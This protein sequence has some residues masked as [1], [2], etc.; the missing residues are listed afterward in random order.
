VLP[1]RARRLFRLAVRRSALLE[2]EVDDEIAFHLEARAAQLVARHMSAEDARAEALRRFGDVG[3]ARQ[4]LNRSATRHEAR[5]QLREL[6]ASTWQ[7]VHY[8]ARGIR[9]SPGFATAVI[10]TLALGIGANA[11]MFGVVDRLLL[12]PPAGVRAPDEVNRIYLTTANGFQGMQLGTNQSYRRY[13]DLVQNVHTVSDIAAHYETERVFGLGE[14]ARQE[15]TSMVTASFWPLIGVRP[16]LGRFFDDAEDRLPRGT[17]VAVLG[18]GYWQSQFGGRRDVL[19]RTLRIGGTDY[20]IVGVV[21]A[22]FSGLSL[23]PVA[24]FVPL[25]A[26]GADMFHDFGGVKWSEQYRV[27]WLQT[28]IR[29]KPGVSVQAATADLTNAFRQSIETQRP[30]E[31]AGLLAMDRMNPQATL[32]SVLESRGPKR[33][34][35]ATVSLWLMAVSGLVLVMACANVANLLIARALRRRREI[36]IRQALGVSR[37]RLLAQLLTE[38][39]LLAL[40]GGVAGVLVAQWGGALLRSVLLPTLDWSGGAFDHRVLLFAGVIALG[41]GL[42]T[43]LAPIRQLSRSDVATAL[44]SGGRGASLRSSRLRKGLLVVQGAVSVILLVGAGLFV[45]SFRNVRSLDLGFQPE[46]VLTA[47]V[48][49]RGVT[50]DSMQRQ[51]LAQQMRD[52]ALTLPGVEHATTGLTVPFSS[53]WTQ[54]IVVPGID[55][56]RLRDF[57]YVV[58]AGPDY[59]ATMGTRLVS[60]RAITDADRAGTE[61]VV[62]VSQGAARRIWPGTNPIGR[63]IKLG[64]DAPCMT[65]IGTAQDTRASFDD[66]PRPQL[67]VPI[68]QES[69]PEVRLFVR[70]RGDAARSTESVRRALQELMPGAAYVNAAA[71]EEVVASESRSWRLGATMFTIFGLLALL[72]AA[73]GLYSVV[74]Y[75][76]SQRTQ[77][78]GVRVALGASTA[79]VI[80]LVL[81]EGVRVVA[82]GLGLGAIV[83]LALANRITPMLY[84][85]TGKDPITYGLVGVVLLAVAIVASLAPALRAAHVDPNVALR[86]E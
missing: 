27:G 74:A 75:D 38:S 69:Q 41:A 81:A 21:P 1:P 47:G 16:V 50:L 59:L 61:R 62:V 7:D 36:A 52:R 14:G 57:F 60:G 6:F 18:Y 76:V 86:A 45:R 49:F 55:T 32:G 29:R 9:R 85:V 63:C 84:H 10:L 22:G 72:V 26:G 37:G 25:T 24:A 19:G 33:S 31:P 54:P 39:T 40:L 17:P 64:G 48:S 3:A 28:V 82:L 51:L 77:E 15:R 53:E 30:V 66:E 42:L 68:T 20:T 56:S 70:T 43:G 2:R 83:A 46:H 13:L 67:Y 12:R 78:L 65:V 58:P 35:S 5:M 71:L 44:R 11:T 23:Q 79:A 4:T 80:R 8:A 73:V 34:Q